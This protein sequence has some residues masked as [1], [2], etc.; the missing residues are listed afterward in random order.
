MRGRQE[1]AQTPRGAQLA[2]QVL[3]VAFL[4]A[5]HELEDPPVLGTNALPCRV[6]GRVQV[7]QVPGKQSVPSVG[8]EARLA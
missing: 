5:V 1:G 6:A 7:G 4:A 8:A 3:H 2:F